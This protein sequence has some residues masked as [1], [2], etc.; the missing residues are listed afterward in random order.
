MIMIILVIM[1]VMK[2]LI[3][4]MV[5]KFEM[6]QGP[7]DALK[8]LVNCKFEPILNSNPIFVDFPTEETYDVIVQLWKY[9]VQLNFIF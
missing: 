9:E 7:K 1:I 3:L 2:A 6:V 8:C 5:M 4:T